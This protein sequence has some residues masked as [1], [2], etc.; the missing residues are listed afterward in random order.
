MGDNSQKAENLEHTAQPA[1]RLAG[2]K[3]TFPNDLFRQFDLTVSDSEQ[4]G[5]FTLRKGNLEFQ[6][7]L[8]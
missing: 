6:R 3:V 7:P 5:L 8:F 1:G 2:H 4:L